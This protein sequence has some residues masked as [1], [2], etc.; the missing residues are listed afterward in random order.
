MWPNRRRDTLL[1]TQLPNRDQLHVEDQQTVRR[2]LPLIRERF[3]DPESSRFTLDHQLQ[4]FG[5]PCDHLIQGER[6]GLTAHD[7]AV[8]HFS[9]RRPTRVVDGYFVS[10]FRVP[11]AY[12]RLE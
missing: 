1:R 7:R 2:P 11:R 6:R 4:A 3:G 5:P 8:K 10:R 9:I 12:A